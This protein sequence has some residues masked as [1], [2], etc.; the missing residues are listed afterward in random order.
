MTV[1]LIKFGLLYSAE[2]NGTEH[3]FLGV[4]LKSLKTH[5]IAKMSEIGGKTSFFLPG[6][7]P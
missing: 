4:I 5:S 1:G 2:R 7:L 3:V 6:P